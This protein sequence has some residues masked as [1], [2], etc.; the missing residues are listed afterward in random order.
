MSFE[1]SKVIEN[2][3]DLAKEKGIKIGELEQKVNVSPGYLSRLLK[4][5]NKGTISAEQLW[6]ISEI[7]GTTMD[8][9]VGY[10]NEG[11]TENEKK[12]IG[13][14]DKLSF[15]TEKSEI[16]WEMLTPMI[17]EPSYIIA[18]PLFETVDRCTEDALGDFRFYKEKVYCSHF[19]DP[20]YVRIDNN[21]FHF[22]FDEFSEREIYIMS[23][24]K[25]EKD[26]SVWDSGVL[27]IYFVV[28]GVNVE[29]V[30]CSAFASDQVNKSMN[31]LYLT[32]N[33]ARA[34]LQLNKS[35]IDAIDRFLK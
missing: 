8:L 17:K 32:V 34:N 1:R 21:C 13:F 2:I 6:K 18:H 14:L 28:A 23:V 3:Y 25:R 27:E 22:L 15:K 9:L 29:P 7:L 26:K 10:R 31:H 30:V 11:L 19:Y 33:E 5:D 4:D 24:S 16:A 20:E 12:I 35:K